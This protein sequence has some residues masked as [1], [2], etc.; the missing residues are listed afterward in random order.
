M[1][2]SSITLH[3]K[4]ESELA[5]LQTRQVGNTCSFHV[6]GSSVRLLLNDTLAPNTLSEEINRLW[7]RGRFMRVAPNWAVTPRMQVR[8]VRYLAKTRGLPLTATY[9]RGE[10]GL[11]P[12]ILSDQTMTP[13]ITLIWPWRQA[14]PIYLGST[15]QNLNNS[16]SAGGHSMLLAAYDPDHTAENRFQTPWGFINPWVE[17][18]THLFWM[19]DADF[20]RAWRFWLPGIGP[21][22]LV[23]IQRHSEKNAH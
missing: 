16:R 5:A 18:G 15:T 6:I 20:R 2:A 1:N 3:A 9:Q 10:P 11:L 4:S 12:A 14:P 21:N 19:A 22:P 8:I 7:W 13:I 17:N 23:L